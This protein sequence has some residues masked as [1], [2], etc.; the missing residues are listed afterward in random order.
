MAV[1][2]VISFS[3]YTSFHINLM[4]ELYMLFILENCLNIH[5]CAVKVSIVIAPQI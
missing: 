1:E 5:F 4:I 2:K 3:F